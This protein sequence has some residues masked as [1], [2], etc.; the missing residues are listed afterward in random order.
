MLE[1]EDISKVIQ[2]EKQGQAGSKTSLK[3]NPPVLNL[4]YRLTQVFLFHVVAVF[5]WRQ[6]FTR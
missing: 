1:E 2:E 3:Q 6:Y 4:G 5:F